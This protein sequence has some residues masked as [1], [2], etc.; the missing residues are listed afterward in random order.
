MHGALSI[1]STTY[2]HRPWLCKVSS[3]PYKSRVI[4]SLPNFA[5]TTTICPHLPTTSP[6]YPLQD[7]NLSWLRYGAVNLSCSSPRQTLKGQGVRNGRM[8]ITESRPCPKAD[9]GA[10][11]D[12]LEPRGR[13][14]WG[15]FPC[16]SLSFCLL[17]THSLSTACFASA[18]FDRFCR[19]HLRDFGI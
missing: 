16:D 2:H 8:H 10:F 6:G 17:L 5:K 19:I 13:V 14:I 4:S 11:V 15:S 1:L 7:V 3:G 9:E 18:I 12:C